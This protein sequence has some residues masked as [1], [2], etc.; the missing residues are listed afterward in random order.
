MHRSIWEGVAAKTIA[1][2]RGRIKGRFPK[3]SPNDSEHV[4][5][6]MLNKYILLLDKLLTKRRKYGIIYA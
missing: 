3:P 2:V 5:N 6:M 4:F 1:G